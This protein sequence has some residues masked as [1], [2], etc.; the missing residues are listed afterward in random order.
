MRG[1]YDINML[2]VVAVRAALKSPSYVFDYVKEL[3]EKSKPRLEAYLSSKEIVFWPST[4]ANYIFAYIDQPQQA[5]N[6]HL[7]SVCA[8]LVIL[9]SVVIETHGYLS[10]Q[11]EAALRSRGIL[12]RPKK[13]GDGVTGLRMSIGTLAQTER[14]IGALDE[15]L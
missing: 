4:G 2:S 14:L 15:I 12:V 9:A 10:A 6:D 11:R 8:R 13:D 3:N 1:P 5:R 7:I